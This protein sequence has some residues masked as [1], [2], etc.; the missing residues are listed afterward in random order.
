M[1]AQ[2]GKRS[3]CTCCAFMNGHEIR[4]EMFD[5]KVSVKDVRRA[6]FERLFKNGKEI[7]V[8]RKG[9]KA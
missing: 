9:A 7:P 2:H 6:Q 3:P 1:K 8:E 4:A 5:I